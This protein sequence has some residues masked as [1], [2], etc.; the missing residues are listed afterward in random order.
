MFPLVLLRDVHWTSDS[1]PDPLKQKG[2]LQ[3]A[4]IET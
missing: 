2:S 1:F 4:K 3:A